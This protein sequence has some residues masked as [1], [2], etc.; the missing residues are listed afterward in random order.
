MK[1]FTVTIAAM[2]GMLSTMGQTPVLSTSAP[3]GGAP[4]YDVMAA[5]VSTRAYSTEML[6]DGLISGLLWS[7]V[8]VT[9][10]D[11]KLTTPTA[12]NKQEVSVYLITPA[13][14]W[15][16]DNKNNT[17]VEVATGNEAQQVAAPK[18]WAVDAPVNVA[19]V[20]DGALQRNE[21]MAGVDAG[22]VMQNLYLYCAAN[23]LGTCARGGVDREKLGELLKLRPEQKVV[24]VQSVG[25][26][27]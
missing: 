18:G 9:H 21:L 26:K 4:V 23:D 27:K 1:K 2:L 22:A 6:S 7:A 15:L 11:G 10:G 8:G 24:I 17:L 12:S 16:Y 3:T 14:A 20:T 25:Y 5:R 13:G 19:I